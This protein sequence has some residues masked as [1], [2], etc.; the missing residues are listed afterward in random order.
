VRHNGLDFTA[1]YGET[2][3]ACADGIVTFVGFQHRT[4]QGVQVD[5]AHQDPN[6]NIRN[7]AGDLVGT[8]NGPPGAID[9]GFGGI[10]V[11]VV[12][13]GDFQNYRT[14]YMHLSDTLVRV[15]DHVTEGQPIAKAG[16]SGGYYGHFVKGI[17][18]HFQAAFRAGRWA[19]VRPS[20]LVP[21]YWPPSF[22]PPSKDG[23]PHEDSTTGTGGRSPPNVPGTAPVGLGAIAG[24]SANQI[25]AIDRATEAENQRAGDYKNMQSA[26]SDHVANTLVAQQSALYEA[27][28][29]FQSGGLE[30]ENAM[31]FDFSTGT[32]APDG[33]VV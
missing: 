7:R 12:H 26:H 19:I 17:H 6:G 14:E 8:G 3:Y 32:W 28:G 2:I 33:K 1:D 24:N 25:Q 20:F 22:S 10:I 4:R 30:V 11:F 18:L 21:N 23:I 31:T 16:G 15:G 13:N 27:I 9:V 5:G 29:K